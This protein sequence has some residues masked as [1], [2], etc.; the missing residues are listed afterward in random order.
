MALEKA[1]I[2]N[3]D[4]NEVVTV[5]FN[6]QEYQLEKST[7]WQEHAIVG[8]D[9]PE[10]EFTTGSRRSLAMELFFDTY[11]EKKDVREFTDKIEN[12]LYVNPDT[13]RPPI[14]L[15]AWGKLDFKCVLEHLKQRFTMFLEDGTP[16]RAVLGVVFREYMTA[17]EQLERKPRQSADRTKRRLVKRGDT[18][19]MIAA[20][21]YG[22]AG[23]WR[24]IADANGILDPLDI[25]PGQELI[26]PP[27]P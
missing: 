10:V 24:Y 27:L 8:L 11:E 3:L 25:R 9:M 19:N 20:R 16:V 4:T 7:P 26:I 5:L 15:F 2:T 6:P 23:K 13:H 17:K 22:D 1:T 18:L 14:L 21:E 12:L